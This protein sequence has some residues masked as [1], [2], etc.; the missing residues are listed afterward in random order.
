MTSSLTIVSRRLFM[1]ASAS[2][3]TVWSVSS[4]RIDRLWWSSW[5]S[6]L[7]WPL[8]WIFLPY[9]GMMGGWSTRWSL[10]EQALW[11]S[12]LDSVTDFPRGIQNCWLTRANVCSLPIL[13]GSVSLKKVLNQQPGQRMFWW[14]DYL[15]LYLKGYRSFVQTVTDSYN[16]FWRTGC[17]GRNRLLLESARLAWRS[18][19]S[20]PVCR[21]GGGLTLFA[22]KVEFV[23][24]PS[25]VQPNKPFSSRVHLPFYYNHRR[26]EQHC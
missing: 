19:Y 10:L 5:L 2:T 14:K 20:L 25:H 12:I 18:L 9:V 26:G 11:W 6:L 17:K 4:G 24:D 15:V 21:S 22:P 8:T 16:S 3:R 1:V 13:C 7:A 23:P